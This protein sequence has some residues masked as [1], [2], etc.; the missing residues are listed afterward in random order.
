MKTKIELVEDKI[1]S[2]PKTSVTDKI[3]KDIQKKKLKTITK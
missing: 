1:K 3:L 2:M